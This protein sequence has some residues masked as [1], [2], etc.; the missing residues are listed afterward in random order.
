MQATIPLD[1]RDTPALPRGPRAEWGYHLNLAL[2]YHDSVTHRWAED[3]RDFIAEQAGGGAVQSTEVNISDLRGSSGFT[4]GIQAVAKADAIVVAVHE[5]NRLPGEFYLWVNLW[6]QVRSG[7]PGALVAVVGRTG[8]NSSAW[9][10]TRR[11]LHDVAHQGGLEL[12]MKECTPTDS[13]IRFE[14]D[15]FLPMARAA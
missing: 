8:E 6:L 12:F 1:H 15:D 10:E 13:R 11:Y 2:V 3:V 4:R 14:P 9:M 7:R 5:S